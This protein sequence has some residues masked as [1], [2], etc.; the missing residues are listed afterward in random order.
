M[1]TPTRV[2]Q[3]EQHVRTLAAT[4]DEQIEIVSIAQ[5]LEAMHKNDHAVAVYA[6]VKR[7]IL[8]EMRKEKAQ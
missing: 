5:S 1:N 8:R 6:I 7:R 2:R 3:I 4:P